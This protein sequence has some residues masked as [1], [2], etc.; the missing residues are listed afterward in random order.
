M[1]WRWKRSKNVWDEALIISTRRVDG[2]IEIT[3]TDDELK[4][5]VETV[6]PLVLSHAFRQ[7]KFSSILDKKVKE[8]SVDKKLQTSQDFYS[9]SMQEFQKFPMSSYN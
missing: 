4:P 2:Q 9:K 5:A 6:E 8:G 3:A 7:D 1:L